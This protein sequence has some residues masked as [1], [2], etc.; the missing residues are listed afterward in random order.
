MSIIS[1]LGW[2]YQPFFKL[3]LSP[4]QGSILVRLSEI[5]PV[6]KGMQNWATSMHYW[7][8]STLCLMSLGALGLCVHR[9]EQKGGDSI[10]PAICPAN[11]N[12]AT[13]SCWVP[14]AAQRVLWSIISKDTNTSRSI[15]MEPWPPSMHRN[16]SPTKTTFW[17][18]PCPK[19]DHAGVKTVEEVK[20]CCT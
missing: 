14:D 2:K 20:H 8:S 11:M 13:L 15:S 17:P 16:R 7:Q 9:K 10:D 4:S 18:C 6:G 12:G 19:P 5:D 3:L 1:V